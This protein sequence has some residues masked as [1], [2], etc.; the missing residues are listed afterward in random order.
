MT[1]VHYITHAERYGVEGV[2]EAAA[3]ELGAA[4]ERRLRELDAKWRP[5]LAERTPADTRE[6]EQGSRQG[7]DVS[8]SSCPVCGGPI[9]G[10]RSTRRFCSDR[11]R[12]RSHRE[13]QSS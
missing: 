13:H 7:S 3:D 1:L 8:V 12:L 4:L 11:C 2:F 6:V 9:R 10:K 5:T